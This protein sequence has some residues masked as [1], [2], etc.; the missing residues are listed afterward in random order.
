MCVLAVTVCSLCAC[1]GAVDEAGKVTVVVENRDGS[2]KEYKANLEDIENKDEGAV[3]VIEYLAA[4][5]DDPLEADLQDSSYG[6]FVNSI[7]GL[8]PDASAGEF[9]S[10]YTSVEADFGTFDGVGEINYNGTTLKSAGVGLT[11][12]QVLEG[13]VI[14]FRIEVSSW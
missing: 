4:R 3:G 14:L 7:G 1:F 2:Y 13:T 8:T 6:K 12:M 11:S 9:V 5:S 10:I